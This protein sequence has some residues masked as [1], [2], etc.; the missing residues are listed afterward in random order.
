[1]AVQHRSFDSNRFPAGNQA[2]LPS[3]FDPLSTPFGFYGPICLWQRPCTLS[4]GDGAQ[5]LTIGSMTESHHE[6]CQDNYGFSQSLFLNADFCSE[7]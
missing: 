2:R 7:S 4:I 1:M 6:L 3:E 5:I